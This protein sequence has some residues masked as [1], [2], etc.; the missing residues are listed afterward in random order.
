M[1]EMGLAKR[2]HS[3]D[4]NADMMRAD[5][6]KLGFKIDARHFDLK[7]AQEEVD[8]ALAQSVPSTTEKMEKIAADVRK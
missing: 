1:D 6:S 2:Y 4:L 8:S 7:T 3:L 5:L